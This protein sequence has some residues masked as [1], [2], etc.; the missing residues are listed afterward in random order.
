MGA[1]PV[2]RWATRGVLALALLLGL[3]A[4]AGLLGGLVPRN[5]GWRPPSAGGVTIFVEDNG[6]HTGLVVPTVAAGVDWR[7][8][9]LAADLRDPRYAAYDHLAIGWGERGFFLDTPH[10]ADL[11]PATI[12]H[13]AVGSDDTLLHVEHVPRPALARHTRA[14]TLRPTEYRR[15][16]D[17]IRAARAQGAAIPGYDRH[18]AF[19]PAHGHYD[20]IRTCNQWTGDTL[21][22]AGVR[23]GFWTPFP[24]TVMRWF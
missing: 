11:R 9:F 6:I 16:A 13:A 12:L 15:L 3:Y 4:L 23:I 10:W 24:I 20:A 22:K 7:A 19:Y 17:L 5:A 2:A 8:D 18:D 1:R 21:A 14:I